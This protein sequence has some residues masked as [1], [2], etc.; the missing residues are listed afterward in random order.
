MYMYIPNLKIQIYVTNMQAA[1]L[2]N[3]Y[4]MPQSAGDIKHV[5][6]G[7]VGDTCHRTKTRQPHGLLILKLI[8]LNLNCNLTLTI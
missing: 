2:Y 5:T 8:R 7:L 4:L 3:G 6:A 1:A